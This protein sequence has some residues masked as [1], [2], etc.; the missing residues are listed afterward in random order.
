MSSGKQTS[1]TGDEQAPRK[2]LFTTRQLLLLWA[3]VVLAGWILI[4]NKN[5]W[6]LSPFFISTGTVFMCVGWFAVTLVAR[7]LWRA[8]M[9]LA[10][11]EDLEDY[12]R[13]LGR[14]HELEVEKATMLK[15]IKEIEFDHSLGKTTEEDAAELTQVYRARAIAVIKAIDALD[16]DDAAAVTVRDKIDRDVKARIELA[17]ASAKKTTKK[18]KKKNQSGRAEQP[19]RAS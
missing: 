18:K 16:D 3:V 15:A 11:D 17:N 4:F 14:R 5:Q 8:G 9:T 7:F 10:S 12:F 13:P 1:D 2:T 6:G 19:E